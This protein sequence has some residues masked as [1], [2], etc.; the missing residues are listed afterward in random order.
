MHA[1]KTQKMMSAITVHLQWTFCARFFSVL[2]AR[3]N[4]G[5]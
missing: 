2:Y 4:H 5:Q 1:V 3:H